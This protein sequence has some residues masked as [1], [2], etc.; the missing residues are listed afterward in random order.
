MN[1]QIQIAKDQKSL[2]MTRNYMWQAEEALR[3][4]DE[5]RADR[6]PLKI[7]GE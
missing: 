2:P 4:K 1:F 7:A 6:R 5:R 3:V